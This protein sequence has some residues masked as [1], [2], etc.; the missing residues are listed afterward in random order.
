MRKLLVFQHVPHEPLGTLDAQF[1]EA[2]FRIRYVNFARY[3]RVK[4][5]VGRYDGLVV[6]GGPMGVNDTEPYP[7]LLDEVE[8]IRVAIDSDIPIL[9]ICLGAQ[10]IAAA[11]GARIARNPVKEIGWSDVKRTRAAMSDPLF[12][13]FHAQEKIF[14]WHG[15]TFEI[16]SGAKHL[17][18]TD[19][20]RN[21]A[22]CYGRA[23]YALQFH[24]EV[25]E[26]LV[27]RWLATPA[28]REELAALQG[29]VSARAILEETHRFIGRSKRLSQAVF[30]EFIERSFGWRRRLALPSR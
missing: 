22:F 29:A 15:D 2:G 26:A 7:H 23:V 11:L 25:D 28:M 14:Q 30:N 21:Q 1:K 27:R 12:K 9:G 8:A 4:L 10:L 18:M 3:G 19:H 17:A 20:C 24:L 6:L 13:H 5:D 16:P